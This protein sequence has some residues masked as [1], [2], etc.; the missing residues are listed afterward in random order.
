MTYYVFFSLLQVEKTFKVDVASHNAAWSD[1]GY[2]WLPS[3]KQIPNVGTTLE[4][5]YLPRKL[6]VSILRLL[7]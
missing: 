5:E 4:S 6:D 3:K 7:L 1:S 2:D